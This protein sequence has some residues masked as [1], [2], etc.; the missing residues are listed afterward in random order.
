MSTIGAK[1]DQLHD[2]RE[3]KRELEEQVNQLK[4]QMAELENE[5]IAE[6]DKQGVTKSTGGAATVSISSTV[7]PSVDDWDAFYAYIHRHKYYHLLERR[8][9]VSGCN[10]LLE[11]KGKIPGVVPYTQRKLNIRSV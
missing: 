3:Q 9:S 7:R 8:P 10:E 4:A 11:V 2:L 5:L 6:M 1:I